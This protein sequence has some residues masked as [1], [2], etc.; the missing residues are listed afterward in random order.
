MQSS[1]RKMET[2]KDHD[3]KRHSDLLHQI[4]KGMKETIATA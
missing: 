3:I 1:E 4:K 2:K